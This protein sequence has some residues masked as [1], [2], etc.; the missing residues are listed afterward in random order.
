MYLDN[1]I[2]GIENI[3]DINTTNIDNI[4]ANIDEVFNKALH[5]FDN[6][7]ELLN[8]RIN[9]F[10]DDEDKYSHNDIP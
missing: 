10:E 7:N 3:E 2:E 4:F 8:E 5:D 6:C 1:V 9:T